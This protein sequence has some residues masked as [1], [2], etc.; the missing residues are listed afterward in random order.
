MKKAILFMKI[1]KMQLT[2][3]TRLDRDTFNYRFGQY[4]QHEKENPIRKKK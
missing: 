4:N 2:G 3:L 1:K